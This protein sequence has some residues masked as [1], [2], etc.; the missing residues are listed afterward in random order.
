M[1]NKYLLAPSGMFFRS[2][3]YGAPLRICPTRYLTTCSM[4]IQQFAQNI[5]NYIELTTSLMRSKSFMVFDKDVQ[6]KMFLLFIK[7]M[8][9]KL[10]PDES[11]LLITI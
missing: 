2:L 6:D 11:N 3:T 4:S 9:T 10:G 1:P 5:F 8:F 7:K